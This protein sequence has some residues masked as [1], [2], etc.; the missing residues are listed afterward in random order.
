MLKYKQKKR[1]YTFF[2]CLKQ[3]ALQNP[4]AAPRHLFLLA[5]YNV[6]KVVSSRYESQPIVLARDCMAKPTTFIFRS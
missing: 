2:F 3:P 6:P 4:V 5:L 1:K